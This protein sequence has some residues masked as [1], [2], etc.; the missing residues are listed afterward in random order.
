ML[1]RR[2]TP[3]FGCADGGPVFGHLP[4]RTPVLREGVLMWVIRLSKRYGFSK[5]ALDWVSTVLFRSVE[6][7]G[8]PTVTTSAAG[9]SSM[10]TVDWSAAFST[11]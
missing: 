8:F 5:M 2:R 10:S 1:K 4:V 11:R 3:R 6:S 7:G 9:H